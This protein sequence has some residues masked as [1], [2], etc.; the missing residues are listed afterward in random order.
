MSINS[1]TGFHISR[2]EQVHPES[3]PPK[4]GNKEKLAIRRRIED[5]QAEKRLKET[6]GNDYE[7]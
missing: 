2:T 1:M 6:C 7:L 5:L 4:R 3:T